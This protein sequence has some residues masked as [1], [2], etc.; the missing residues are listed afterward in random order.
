MAD[1][2]YRFIL[3]KWR[4]LTRARGRHRPDVGG[5][6]RHR[7]REN[8]RVRKLSPKVRRMAA[9]FAI[10][11]GLVLVGAGLASGVTPKDAQ[12]LPA[13]IEDVSPVRNAS[14]VQQQERIQV[15]L[16]E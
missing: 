10:A 6:I 15:D 13:D 5:G 2:N 14:Q 8:V 12:K 11:V 9:S 16:E 1:R 4:H 3:P 7:H